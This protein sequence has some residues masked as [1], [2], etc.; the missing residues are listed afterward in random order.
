MSK[1]S[2]LYA[3][4]LTNPSRPLPFRQF[5]QIVAAFGFVHVRTS[6]SHRGWE[7]P[8]VPRLLVLQPRGKDAKPYQQG[9][10]LDMVQEYGL[11]I[12]E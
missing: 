10:F 7:H 9:Q 2:K 6:G 1:S 11:K 3:R 12:E 4:L 5:E 8:R